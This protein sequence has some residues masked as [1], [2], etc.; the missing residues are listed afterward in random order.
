M[1]R[2]PILTG[3]NTTPL[4]SNIRTTQDALKEPVTMGHGREPSDPGD[5]DSSA[6][7]GCSPHGPRRRS[8]A[9]LRAPRRSIADAARTNA[10][11]DKASD[12]TDEIVR[13]EIQDAQ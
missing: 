11:I 3:V 9:S 6:H 10:A 8:D 4:Y 2:R 12:R 5:D 1:P 7:N 13:Q